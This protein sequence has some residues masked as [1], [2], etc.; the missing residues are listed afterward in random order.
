MRA[1]LT[2]MLVLSHVALAAAQNDQERWAV[3]QDRAMRLLTTMTQLSDWD[4]QHAYMMEAVEKTYGRAGWSSES[5]EFSLA[6]MREVNAI[7][8]WS[9]LERFDRAVEILGGR[10]GLDADQEQVLRGLAIRT[11]T[12][13]FQKHSDRIM[14]YAVEAIQTR[15]AGEPFTSEQVARWVKLAE[16][17]FQDSRRRVNAVTQTFMKELGEDQQVLVQR[18]LDAMNR[19]MADVE[20]MSRKWAQG[21]WQPSDWGLEADP[22]QTGGM[23]AAATSQDGGRVGERPVTVRRGNGE[24]AKEP[25]RTTARSTRRTSGQERAPTEKPAQTRRQASVSNRGGGSGASNDP[26]AQYVQRFID[27][28]QLDDVQQTKAWKIYRDVK[29]RADKHRS[30]Y[31]QQIDAARQ[32]DETSDGGKSNAAARELESKL[33]ANLDQ[34]F[35]RLKQRLERLPT[36]AQRR[37]AKPGDLDRS[38]RKATQPVN[39]VENDGP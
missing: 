17:V 22:I 25:E 16:P 4:T 26:W 32:R 36:R 35:E 28:Y 30:R 20:V 31:G 33:Q 34:L 21:E 2:V 37:D 12:E 11:S 38:P 18:D 8:P 29:A 5:D 10:Y 13:M 24:P 19:R 27:K 39:P 14:Q 9:P 7:P 15:A 23:A 6:L 3:L 1:V